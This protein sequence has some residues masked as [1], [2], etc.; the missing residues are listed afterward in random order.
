MLTV[1]SSPMFYKPTVSK[2][3][4]IFRS[5]NLVPLKIEFS[6]TFVHYNFK[7][8]CSEDLGIHV[9]WR[10]ILSVVFEIF[11]YWFEALKRI[12]SFFFFF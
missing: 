3:Y 9:F 7:M 8:I 12:R 1:F 2:W 4:C 5:R 6:W 10:L 11:M